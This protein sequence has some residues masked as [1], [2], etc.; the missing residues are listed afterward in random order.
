MDVNK[1]KDKLAKL[2][3]VAKN[4]GSAEGEASNALRMAEA[5]MRKFGLEEADAVTEAPKNFDWSSQFVPYVYDGCKAT[6]MPPWIQ[7]MAVGVAEFTDTVAKIHTRNGGVGIGFYGE[8]SDVAFAQWL[9]QYLIDNVQ[10]EASAHV[11]LGR[12]GRIQFRTA[13]ASRISKR[14]KDLRAER[15]EAFAASTGTA[16]VVVNR[17][18]EERNQEFGA[19]NYKTTKIEVRDRGAFEAGCAAGNK[20]NFSKPISGKQA[21]AQLTAG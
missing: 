2:M 10:K 6:K 20:V 3:A 18:I 8:I 5:I 17:K 11:E 4:A 9:L 15:T 1:A 12:S 19:S 21:H 7:C 14:M 13:M 16:L